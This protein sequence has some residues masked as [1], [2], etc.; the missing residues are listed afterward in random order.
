MGVTKEVAMAERAVWEVDTLLSLVKG[1]P[2][3]P[4]FAAPQRKHISLQDSGLGRNVFSTAIWLRAFMQGP[5]KQFC[6]QVAAMVAARITRDRVAC[7][8]G[9]KQ[10]QKYLL[11]HSSLVLSS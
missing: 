3:H 5:D 1:S 8:V 10:Q 7:K 11:S 9:A 4:A 2:P 6:L